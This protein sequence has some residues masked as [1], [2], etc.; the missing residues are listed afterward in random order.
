M[1]QSIADCILRYD[2]QADD[3]SNYK[4]AHRPTAWCS[5][6][7]ENGDKKLIFGDAGG[8]CYTFGGTALD[9]AGEPI[10]SIMEGVLFGEFVNLDKK[11]NYYQAQANPG[12][13]AKL[14]FAISDTFTKGKK[15][16]F[17]A[18]QIL[19]GVLEGKFPAGSR[20]KLL[21][22]KVTEASKTSRFN[23]YGLTVDFDYVDRK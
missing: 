17:D 20:G 21:F 19:D 22:W 9:D 15:K 12:C 4:F 16:W 11:W 14:Q 10:E 13:Q 5:Y 3:W 7:D 6:N 2:Y 18:G 23:F 8:Q 1:L